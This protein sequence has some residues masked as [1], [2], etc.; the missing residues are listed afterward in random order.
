LVASAPDLHFVFS[1]RT[2]YSAC[3]AASPLLQAH[4]GYIPVCHRLCAKQIEPDQRLVV[5]GVSVL[6][7]PIVVWAVRLSDRCRHEVL[8][9]E[10][11]VLG[12]ARDPAI[13]ILEWMNPSDCMVGPRCQN[14]RVKIEG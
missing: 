12:A 4:S 14:Q 8:L 13:P 1:G 7:R 11:H 9:Q 10:N 5:T 2:H 3:P 6:K